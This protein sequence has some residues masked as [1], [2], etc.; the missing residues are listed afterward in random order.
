M[1]RPP[2]SP[3]KRDP[4]QASVISL[5]GNDELSR[6]GVQDLA[7]ALRECDIPWYQFPIKDFSIPNPDVLQKVEEA[8]PEILSRLS[9]H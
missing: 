1:A 2:Q 9:N 8:L 7:Q 3:L 5:L 4:R 6:H